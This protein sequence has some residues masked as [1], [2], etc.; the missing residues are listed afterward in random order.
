[1]TGHL[2]PAERQSRVEQDDGSP[3][4][5]VFVVRSGATRY[6]DRRTCRYV[7]RATARVEE[8]TR[9]AVQATQRAAPCAH[10]VLS[11]SANEQATPAGERWSFP[12]ESES[13]ESADD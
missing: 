6:H 9:K 12:L 5:T 2:P 4:D 3:D 1:M 11:G 10:C 13:A 8:R 7:S